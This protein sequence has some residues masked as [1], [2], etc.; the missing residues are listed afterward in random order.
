MT[1]YT[2]QNKAHSINKRLENFGLAK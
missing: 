1:I 2:I